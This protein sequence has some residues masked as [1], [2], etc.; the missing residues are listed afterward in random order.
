[1]SK[2]IRS[3]DVGIYIENHGAKPVVILY[4]NHVTFRLECET[5]EHAERVY[6]EVADTFG[7]W[8]EDRPKWIPP[9]ETEDHR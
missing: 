4:V 1:M 8:E 7:L 6:A 3:S 5:V 9:R 2:R